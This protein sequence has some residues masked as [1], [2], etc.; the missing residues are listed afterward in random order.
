MAKN[1]K[2]VSAK[3]NKDDKSGDSITSKG[4]NFVNGKIVATEELDQAI[5]ENFGQC[6]SISYFD[7][8]YLNED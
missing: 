8:N 2:E 5:L 3:E 4:I 6:P 7:P 1:S